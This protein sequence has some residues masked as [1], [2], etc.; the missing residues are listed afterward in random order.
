MVF[1]MF[2]NQDKK[3]FKTLINLSEKT[4]NLMEGFISETAIQEQDRMTIKEYLEKRKKMRDKYLDFYNDTVDDLTK[5]LSN[6]LRHFEITEG[7]MK[8]EI[9]EFSETGERFAWYV[10]KISE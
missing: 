1:G 3:K 4:I 8:K 7:A 10:R 2:G 9:S 6:P 5:R